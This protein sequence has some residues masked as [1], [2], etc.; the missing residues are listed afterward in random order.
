M[1]D[2]LKEISQTVR[3]QIQS[4]EASQ[5]TKHTFGLWCVCVREDNR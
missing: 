2:E 4:S 3:A 1:V 5:T